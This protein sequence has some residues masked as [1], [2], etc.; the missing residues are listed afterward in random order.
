MAEVSNFVRVNARLASSGAARREFGRVFFFYPESD[1][2]TAIGSITKAELDERTHLVNQA[3]VY[4][5]LAAVDADFDDDV[6]PY[7]A[8]AIHFQQRPYPRNLVTAAWYES[9]AFA[10][11]WG[12]AIAVTANTS[13]DMIELTLAGETLDK[14]TLG[15]QATDLSGIA[16]ALETAIQALSGFSTSV[17]VTLQTAG[18]VNRLV[19]KIPPAD[20][21]ALTSAFAG[22]DAATLGLDDGVAILYP[23]LPSETIANSLGRVLGLDDSWYWGTLAPAIEDDQTDV[24]AAASWFSGHPLQLIVGS[25]DIETL[26][27]DE[28]SSTLA[29]LR[30]LEYDRVT[31]IYSAKQ[32]YK[33]VSLAARFSSVDF[34]GAATQLTAN[35]NRYPGPRPIRFP[36]RRRTSSCASGSISIPRCR[37]RRSYPRMELR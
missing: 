33:P 10:Y 25:D 32:D 22:A 17:E 14:T 21:D 7:K 15:N 6:E 23:G 34:A 12:G 3:N 24:L 27:A 20:V 2:S 5:S 30:D 11:I 36:R 35:S 26:T 9:G 4:A 29:M 19:V 18:S 8:A 1:L 37:A 31:A 13:L 28:T 16:A